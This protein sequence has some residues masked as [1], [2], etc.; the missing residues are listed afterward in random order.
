MR[1][2]PPE[3]RYCPAATSC[4]NN[5]F[6]SNS[7]QV[8]IRLLS[9]DLSKDLEEDRDA[10][11]EH[12]DEV[13]EEKGAAAVLVA[14][15]GEAPHVAEAHGHRD[16]AE[17]EVQLVAPPAALVVLVGL[18]AAAVG[19]V[20]VRRGLV[21]LRRRLE[22]LDVRRVDDD[23]ARGLGGKLKW[24]Q[25]RMIELNARLKKVRT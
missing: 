6:A 12:G 11:G 18:G 14:E 19:G 23:L 21:S 7:F 16:A 15:V 2:D 24:D 20:D 10:A 17:E 5:K 25:F 3:P 13:D 8:R 9:T 1:V 4:K 22:D